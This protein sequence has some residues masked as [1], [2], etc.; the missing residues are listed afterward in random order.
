MNNQ[1]HY[2]QQRKEKSM[3]IRKISPHRYLWM[4]FLCSASLLA[5]AGNSI[6]V[7]AEEETA[8]SASEAA[9][10]ED[11]VFIIDYGGSGTE[12]ENGKQE[13]SEE[14][15][16]EEES[17]GENNTDYTDLITDVYSAAAPDGYGGEYEYHIPQIHLDGDE[18]AAINSE[19]YNELYP[20]IE[21]A[22]AA[23]YIPDYGDI[24][25]TWSVH[26]DTL[27]LLISV[28]LWP[29]ASG[30]DV[31]SSYNIS[32]SECRELSRE[33]MLS[34]FGCTTG[35]FENHLS[36]LLALKWDEIYGNASA[37]GGISEE[38]AAN[39]RANTLSSENLNNA[40]A[41]LNADGE[42]CA[43]CGYYVP[44]GGGYTEVLINMISDTSFYLSDIM[45]E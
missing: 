44:A 26:D 42:V 43:A 9:A 15:N 45:G 18:I 11:P 38:T 34:R 16:A 24:V 12:G 39:C 1:K 2:T 10:E 5:A 4:S 17:A 13:A 14:E 3:F 25:Y 37:S 29:D 33:E 8:Q 19:I 31:F 32:I 35:D 30:Y 23:E 20:Y 28:Y 41:F 40:W 7:R 27:S 36:E 21:S 22:A 6:S